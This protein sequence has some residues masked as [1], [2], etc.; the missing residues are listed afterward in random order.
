ME[1]M[2]VVEKEEM[3][4]EFKEDELLESSPALARVTAR[5]QGKGWGCG[6]HSRGGCGETGLRTVQETGPR[7]MQGE[8]WLGCGNS[9]YGI[10]MVHRQLLVY[11]YTHH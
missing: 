1:K 8:G 7:T 5:A 6:W 3:F 11:G 9:V 4:K 2:K 10:T